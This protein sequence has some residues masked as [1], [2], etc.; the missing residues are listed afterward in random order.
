[1]SAPDNT[2]MLLAKPMQHERSH[3]SQLL[4]YEKRVINGVGKWREC[5]TAMPPEACTRA[6]I[7]P[8][9]PSL[10][11]GSGEAEV[12]F[13]PRT[14]RETTMTSATESAGTGFQTSMPSHFLTSLASLHPLRGCAKRVL[15]GT[16]TYGARDQTSDQFTYHG[17]IPALVLP[18]G[19]MAV[20][21]RKGATA[22][23]LIHEASVLNTDV[24]LKLVSVDNCRLPGWGPRDSTHQWLMTLKE[25][26]SEFTTSSGVRQDSC[27]EAIAFIA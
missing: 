3:Q 13:K 12:G 7:L 22:E 2:Q 4:G 17:N 14:F 21:H 26:S 18:S 11:R 5:P 25:L 23:L 6:E 27:I 10:D 20:R 9:C 19:G 16:L 8:G 24:M 15:R 1:M